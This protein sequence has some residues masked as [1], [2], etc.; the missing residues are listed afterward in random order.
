MSYNRP[1]SGPSGGDAGLGGSPG[2]DPRYP[3]LPVG[4]PI[5]GKSFIARPELV[6]SAPRGQDGYVRIGP[7]SEQFRRGAELVLNKR[8]V[9]TADVAGPRRRRPK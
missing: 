9:T 8:S 2:I 1:D 6:T 3:Q 7:G 4:C 5:P